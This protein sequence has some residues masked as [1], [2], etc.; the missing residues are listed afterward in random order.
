M[1]ELQPD[2]AGMH[3]C[4]DG[5]RISNQRGTGWTFYWNGRWFHFDWFD[6]VI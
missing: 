1:D 2:I 4:W 5:N 3:V 6:Q